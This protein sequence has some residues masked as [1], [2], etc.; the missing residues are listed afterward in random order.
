MQS[1][2][3]RKSVR[4]MAGVCSL[5][6][7][8]AVMGTSPSMAQGRGGSGGGMG[9]NSAPHVSSPGVSN[10][11][12]PNSPDRDKGRARAEDRM[13][14]QGADHNKASDSNKSKKQ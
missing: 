10:S 13:S 12:G 3:D 7:A 14:T 1:I 6:A 9:G 2:L 11:N 5:A 8:L 4:V